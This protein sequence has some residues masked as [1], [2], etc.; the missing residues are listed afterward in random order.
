MKK[1]S[2]LFIAILF[3]TI[4]ILSFVQ[5]VVS[6]KLSTAGITL[7]K[8]EDKIAALKIENTVLLSR[9]LARE[10]L[11]N[12]ASA[13]SSLGFVEPKESIVFSGSLPLALKQ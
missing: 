3:L 7:G 6:N 5:V 11:T 13:A 12:L 10:S 9:L 2:G 1:L 4:V 8:T